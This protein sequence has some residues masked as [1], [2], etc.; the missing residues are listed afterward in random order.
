[1][2]LLLLLRDL[3]VIDGTPYAP[4]TAQALAYFEDMDDYS[5]YMYNTMKMS[6]EPKA[7]EAWTG[8]PLARRARLALRLAEGFF[9]DEDTY[10]QNVK[11]CGEVLSAIMACGDTK[12]LWRAAAAGEHKGASPV[13]CTPYWGRGGEPEGCLETH[14]ILSSS[15]PSP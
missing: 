3:L 15:Y 9:E 12:E 1:M 7:R 11:L 5:N 4:A 8:M 14:K 13:A 6:L 10:D 2:S